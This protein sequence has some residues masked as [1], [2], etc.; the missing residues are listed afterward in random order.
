MTYSSNICARTPQ[1]E[2]FW[3]RPPLGKKQLNAFN[4]ETIWKL[5][6]RAYEKRKF[7]AFFR[8]IAVTPRFFCRKTSYFMVSLHIYKQWRP[9]FLYVI[10]HKLKD[11]KK[12]WLIEKCHYPQI[13]HHSDGNFQGLCKV[14]S[15]ICLCWEKR[16]KIK[17][18]RWSFVS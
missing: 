3:G 5:E 16:S 14:L 9:V 1:N 12:S 2:T 17:N 6:I 13:F 10:L 4:S 18:K 11:E 7:Q 8:K 15:W